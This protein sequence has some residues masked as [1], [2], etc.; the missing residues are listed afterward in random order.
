MGVKSLAVG[1]V[2]GYVL[3]AKA[4]RGRYEQISKLSSKVWNSGL[5][6]AGVDK[7]QEATGNAFSSVKDKLS[8]ALGKENEADIDAIEADAVEF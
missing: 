3:G 7:A 2:A 5:V 4:G 1:L 8:E 6:Q